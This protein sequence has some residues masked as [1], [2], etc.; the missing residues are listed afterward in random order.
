MAAGPAP[1]LTSPAPQPT[2]DTVRV[3]IEGAHGQ[4]GEIAAAAGALGNFEASY[5]DLLQ[6][7]EKTRS[8]EDN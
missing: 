8:P 7:V 1:L 4:A 5:G 6:V 2:E 3:I